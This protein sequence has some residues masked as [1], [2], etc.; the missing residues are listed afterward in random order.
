MFTARVRNDGG[1]LM[2]SGTINKTSPVVDLNQVLTGIWDERTWQD[3]HI[4][5]TPLFTCMDAVV[6]E[7][8]VPLPYTVQVPVPA[9]LFGKSGQVYALV[10]KPGDTAVYVP[11]AGV[12]QIQVFGS[13]IQLKAV[14]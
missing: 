3:W 2:Y 6:S 9:L 5:M 14:R 4:V 12:L 1:H 13:S 10:V 7:G 8:S 11:E